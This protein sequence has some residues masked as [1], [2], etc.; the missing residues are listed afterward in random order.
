MPAPTITMAY[1]GLLALMFVAL[2]ARV[3]VRRRSAHAAL[4]DGDDNDLSRRIR[5]HGN[6]A[7]YAP[8]APDILHLS[9][10]LK[11]AKFFSSYFFYYLAFDTMGIDRVSYNFAQS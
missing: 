6:F 11:E 7:E 10:T 8:L 5:A 4:G 2:S 1:A 9:V 3:I